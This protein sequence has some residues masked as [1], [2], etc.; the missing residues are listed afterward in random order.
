VVLAIA[1]ALIGVGTWRAGRAGDIRF[2]DIAK[3]AAATLPL[4]IG[5]ALALAATR[6]LTG[7][8]FGFMPQR[9]IL[10]RFALF[11]AAM[12]AS[13]LGALLTSAALVAGGRTR[14]AGVWSGLLLIGLALCVALQ[15]AAPTIAF[16]IAWPLTAAGAVSALTASGS[17]GRLLAWGPAGLIIVVASAWL[18]VPFHILLQGLDVPEAPAGIVWLA[19]L[20][21]WPLAW[22][23]TPGLSRFAPGVA[24]L[25]A[26]LGLALFMQETRPW[27][28]RHPQAAEPLYVIDPQ[29]GHAWRAD[30]V[31][32]GAWSQAWMTADGGRTGR[33]QLVGLTNPVAAT[34]AAM[35]AAPSPTISVERGPDGAVIL[36]ATPVGGALG[37]RLDMT[38]DTLLI[39]AAVNGKPTALAA[40]GRWTHVRWQAAPEGFTVSFKPV[41]PGRLTLRWS[42]Y[43]AGW[44]VAAK[45]LPPM[46]A[47]VMAWDMAGSTVVVGARVV[48]L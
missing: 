35:V 5:S 34:P 18:G 45:P 25:I 37:M 20:S 1:G 38:C 31:A 13:A 7:A 36:H 27:T 19:A 29:S 41:G 47:D 21:L 17:R 3:G 15:A 2:V 28:P 23:A 32:P 48:G 39:G 11:E 22:P 10:A 6:H 4:L 30:Q 24:A 14:L 44:P 43:L 33:I 26:G 16:L 12:A 42:Q 8:G 46:P 9:P 40:P